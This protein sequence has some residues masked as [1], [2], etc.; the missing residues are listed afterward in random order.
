[1]MVSSKAPRTYKTYA[2]AF[3]QFKK[4]AADIGIDPF[5]ATT[6]DVVDYVAWLGRRGT[7]AATSLQPYLSAIN[8]VY[9]DCGLNP[10]GTGPAKG[11]SIAAVR[12]GLKAAQKAP[13]SAPRRGPLPAASALRIARFACDLS[14]SWGEQALGTA[15][16]TD[17]DA[18]TLRSLRD[19]LAVFV[20]FAT[21]SRPS[22]IVYLD[23]V[24][25]ISSSDAHG[26]VINRDYVKGSTDDRDDAK[27]KVSL[28]FPLTG[29]YARVR[30]ALD[31][32]S[33]LA[34]RAR[35]RAASSRLPYFFELDDVDTASTAL[36]TWLA[37]VLRVCDIQPPAGV[38]YQP[39]S[40]RSG[41]ASACT[42]I[43]IP[44]PRIEFLGGWVPG[45]SALTTHYI[46]PTM[47]A[48]ASAYAVFGHL[49]P[50]LPAA[51]GAPEAVG[52]APP[53]AD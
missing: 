45:S 7:V 20:A 18:T 4:F 11:D 34:R 36:S 53:S 16:L 44:R 8:R 23:L 22:S 19:A 47:I 12:G 38:V 46:D 37:N 39:G 51:V 21:G 27:G 15:E 48:D 29:I 28:T 30:R 17:A 33:S 1:M 26:L 52:G 49:V 50:A 35:S 24:I 3:N 10:P 2:S 43:G 25:G 6:G 5:R 31:V 32:F 14:E 13:R 9:E 40:L 41:M 42:A